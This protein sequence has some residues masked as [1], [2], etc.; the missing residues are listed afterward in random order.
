VCSEI[1][2]GDYK[3]YFKKQSRID[4]NEIE[5]TECIVLSKDSR[6]AIV[7]TFILDILV[8]MCVQ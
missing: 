4:S 5:N 3:Q 8:C 1:L 7:K 2:L 6:T